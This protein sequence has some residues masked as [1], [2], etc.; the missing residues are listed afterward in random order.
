[1]YWTW[2]YCDGTRPL[3]APGISRTAPSKVFSKGEVLTE[4]ESVARDL[5]LL[6]PRSVPPPEGFRL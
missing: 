4:V 2:S 5:R 6:T 1:M 3:L